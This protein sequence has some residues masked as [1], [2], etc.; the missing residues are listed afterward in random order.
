LNQEDIGLEESPSKTESEW[1]QAE[2]QENRFLNSS[3][4]LYPAEGIKILLQAFEIV[5]AAC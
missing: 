2:K 4:T 5:K 1:G 3:L